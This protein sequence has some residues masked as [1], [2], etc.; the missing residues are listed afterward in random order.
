MNDDLTKYREAHAQFSSEFQQQNEILRRYDEVINEKAGKMALRVLD[1]EVKDILR[2][3]KNELHLEMKTMKDQVEL[4][5]DTVNDFMR[6]IDHEVTRIID[7]Y[8]VKENIR[9]G[10]GAAND[11]LAT[12]AGRNLKKQLVMKADKI[13]IEKLY[14]IKSNKEETQCMINC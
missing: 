9:N 6:N 5:L 3:N 8:K 14:E 10:G 2:K 12:D 1:K 13:D 11:I 4:D 7:D